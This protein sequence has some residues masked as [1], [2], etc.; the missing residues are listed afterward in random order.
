[1]RTLTAT[2]SIGETASFRK[3]KFQFQGKKPEQLTIPTESPIAHWRTST[4]T[5]TERLCPFDRSISLPIPVL[6]VHAMIVASCPINETA[7]NYANGMEMTER[8]KNRSNNRNQ[9]RKNAARTAQRQQSF[10]VGVRWQRC[11]AAGT[12]VRSFFSPSRMDAK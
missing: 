8:K 11:S 3:H 12:L 9:R 1:M 5:Q 6:I 4:H 2:P 10:R 7:N